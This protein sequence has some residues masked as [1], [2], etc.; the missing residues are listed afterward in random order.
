MLPE[1]YGGDAGPCA[2]LNGKEIFFVFM[3][4]KRLSFY[5]YFIIL[6]FIS[7]MD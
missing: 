6:I 5:K 7:S 3:S 1:E 4:K 2:D